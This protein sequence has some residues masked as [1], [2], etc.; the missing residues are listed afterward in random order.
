MDKTDEFVGVDSPI[1]SVGQDAIGRNK[2]AAS[3]AGNILRLDA[4][5]GLVVGVM[6]PWGA[7]KT[8]FLNLARIELERNE[9]PVVEFNPWMFSGAEQLIG[10]FFDELAAQFKLKKGLKDASA[11]WASYGDTLATF[12]WVPIA[13]SWFKLVGQLIKMGS[14]FS[15]GKEKGISELRRDVELKLAEL[16]KPVVVVIDDIDRLSTR[17]IRDIFKLVRLTASF[18]NMIYLLSFD[19]GRV[20]SALGDNGLEGRAYLEKILQL[21]VDLPSVPDQVLQGFLFSSIDKGLEGIDQPGK[22]DEKRWPG[23]FIEIVRPLVRSMRDVRRYVAAIPGT[24]RDLEGKVALEDVLAMEAVRIFLPDVFASVRASVTEL[25]DASTSSSSS[26]KKQQ[27]ADTLGAIVSAAHDRSD[28]AK[29]MLYRMFPATEATL[30]SMHYSGDSSAQWR[31]DRLLASADILR[32]YL[33]RMEGEELLAFNQAERAFGLLSNR[34]ELLAFFEACP[35]VQLENVIS[36]LEGYEHDFK[37]EQVVPAV[38]VIADLLTRIPER[39]L[40]FLD[41]G[42][43]IVVS[44]LI[45]R[46]LNSLG[47]EDAV[48]QAVREILPSLGSLSSKLMVLGIVGHREGVGHKL[49]S[50]PFAS[51]EERIWRDEVRA[52]M[53]DQLAEERD[54]MRI[55]WV[56]R[57]QLDADEEVMTL[58]DLPKF[59]KALLAASRTETRSQ[60]GDSPAITRSPRLMWK[61]LLE[62]VDGEENLRARIESARPLFDPKSEIIAL[63]EKHLSGWNPDSFRD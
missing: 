3:F 36:A 44:R 61:G 2:S 54:L 26:T 29:R 10:R 62:L 28:V 50:E 45:Y 47:S 56:M 19:R 15:K 21:G 46:L 12:D 23:L 24:V 6:G 53:A 20:E 22:F 13:G 51:R 49:V 5:K 43:E 9:V 33:E 35:L 59:N 58:P 38:S 16:E 18:P 39:P 30:G 57:S 41:F 31:K 42:P 52:E 34:K 14:L 63:A 40:G 11:A 8:S 17:E 32:F 60:S 7:G 27:V 48:E 4:R 1:E 37:Q 55:L 25:T